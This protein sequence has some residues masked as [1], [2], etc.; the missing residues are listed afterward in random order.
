M[1]HRPCV[2]AIMMLLSICVLFCLNYV[3]ADLRAEILRKVLVGFSKNC[4]F[5]SIP[6]EKQNDSEIT[7][8][9][10]EASPEKCVKIE[11]NK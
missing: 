9:G 8:E 3:M 6:E 1:Y 2:G 5:S 11:K 10:Q 4:Y 7:E